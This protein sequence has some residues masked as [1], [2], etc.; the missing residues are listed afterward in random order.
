MI[1]AKLNILKKLTEHLEGINPDVDP[2]SPYDL[3]GKVFRGRTTFGTEVDVPFLAILEA[4]RQI[5]PNG[6]G[7]AKLIQ[8]EGWTLLIQGFARDDPENPFDPAYDLLAYVQRRLSR[9]TQEAPNGA[10][11]GLYK[12][13]YRLGGILGL[14][15]YQ[16]PIVRPG[17]DDVSD[18]AYFYMPVSI[19][20]TTDLSNPFI[21][22]D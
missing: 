12:D 11:G 17:K 9:I 14:V 7:E 3:R 13:E 5:D 21:E 22:G 20:L 15:R 16:I 2:D 10:T 4:P 8:N 6:G 1:S 19:E 18:S